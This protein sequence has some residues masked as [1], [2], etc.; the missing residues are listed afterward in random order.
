M[1]RR[2]E[3]L[4][5]AKDAETA[6]AA[7]RSGADSVYMGAERFG[8]R[9]QARNPIEAIREATDFAHQYYAKV[10]V[11]LNVLLYDIEFL[12]AQKLIEQ[13]Y[14]VG[15][16]GLIIQDAGLLELDLPAIPLIA[17][18]Q[19]NNATVEKVKFLQDVGFSRVI[20]ARELTLDEI[21]NIRSEATV[22]LECFIHGSLC[23]S[24]SGQCYMSYAIGGRSGNRG[25]CAQP[26]RRLYTVKDQK[27]N[28]IV[29][30]RYLLSL[31]DLN[32]S[33]Y[34]EDLL[35]AGVTAFKIEG[36]LKD[37]AYV[38]NTVGFYRKLLDGI[39]AKK[40]LKQ[41]GKNITD[42]HSERSEAESR[43]L[44]KKDFSA[45]SRQVGTSV[46]M[47]S[48]S[49]D[50]A[51][52]K[53]SSSGASRLNFEPN[54]E[55]TFNRGFTDF[56]LT[57]RTENMLSM[58]TPKSMGEFLGVVREVG[59]NYFVIDSNKQVR[60]GDGLCFFDNEKNLS[61]TA[62]NRVEDKKIFPQKMNGIR[63]GQDIFRNF[64]YE[65]DRKLKGRAAERKVGLSIVLKESQQGLVLAGK[66]EDNN[67][68][69][70]E[71]TD[72]K[73]PAEK[74]D[75]ARKTIIS[76]LTKLG[77]TLFECSDVKLETKDV[78][79]LP[80][81]KLNEARRELIKR[82]L[83]VR[84]AN[85]PRKQGGILRNNISYP[86]KHL[87]YTGNVLNAQ[88][89]AFYRSHGVET[90]EPAAESGIDMTGKVVMTTK[91]CIRRELNLCPKTGSKAEAEPLILLDEQ[92]K[93]F[94]LEFKCGHCGMDV[95]VL[96]ATPAVNNQ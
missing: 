72:T 61:G 25:Q 26:C 12:A 47:T 75:N 54:P 71:I 19:M 51:V 68:A 14:Q 95:V 83:E 17:S 52:F 20:L 44:L 57:G 53:R 88:A 55:K 50:N 40:N 42:C 23:V 43:N 32:L 85:R 27:G 35:D 78:Y 2:I 10:Y 15:I 60:N 58:D 22:E 46:E 67:E 76:Q 37:V 64:D 11:T 90:I 45:S 92:G 96:S 5:P 31:K 80:V 93:E 9:E 6:I 48:G 65:F 82:L 34:L 16:D 81:S 63:K 79:F 94:Q 87:T 66:D 49:F 59:K 69:T 74:K 73:Q 39:L 21:R 91:M 1:T 84:E 36:R 30:D 18:T 70:V 24:A 89:E 4:A 13:L 38:V 8:A 33:Q 3:L 62:V 7:I 41:D 28:I 29:K 77:N 56:G 86:D